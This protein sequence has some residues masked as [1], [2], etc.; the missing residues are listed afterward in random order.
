MIWRWRCDGLSQ[1]FL[2]LEERIEAVRRACEPHDDGLSRH[3]ISV[4]LRT[5]ALPARRGIAFCCGG[6][7]G[8]K[9]LVA[10]SRIQHEISALCPKR[11]NQSL[12]GL[13]S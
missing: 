2:E 13:V 8:Y 9:L 1:A 10:E 7:Y 6:M 3:G 4:Y 12:L 11:F 5:I